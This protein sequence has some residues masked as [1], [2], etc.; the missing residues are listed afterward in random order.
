MEEATIS[1]P[2][3]SPRRAGDAGGQAGLAEAWDDFVVALRRARGRSGARGESLTLSQY[4]LLRPL[5]RQGALPSGK[6][7][8]LAGIAPASAGQMLDGLERD[9]VIER[10]GHPADRRLVTIALTAE[11]RRRLTRKRRA[12]AA[13]RQRFLDAFPAAE[14]AQT[15]RVLRHLTEV[16]GEL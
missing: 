4:E 11:G 9:G 2:A 14:R 16:I 5:P 7:A 6:L 15:E 8:E 1:T 13:R 3:R 12:I 10:S